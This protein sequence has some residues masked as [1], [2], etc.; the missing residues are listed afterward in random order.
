MTAR[1]SKTVY[2]LQFLLGLTEKRNQVTA[3]YS[4]EPKSAFLPQ[5]WQKNRFLKGVL[6]KYSKMEVRFVFS[7]KKYV[8]IVR[9]QSFL[10]ILDLHFLKIPDYKLYPTIVYW[11]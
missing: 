7:T 9:F 3:V 5:K 4:K 8:R 11:K 2:S 10:E 6:K 1:L